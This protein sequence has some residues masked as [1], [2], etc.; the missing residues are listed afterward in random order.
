MTLKHLDTHV[1]VELDRMEFMV[2]TDIAVVATQP[3]TIAK[4]GEIMTVP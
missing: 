3:P 4:A 2:S 1:V